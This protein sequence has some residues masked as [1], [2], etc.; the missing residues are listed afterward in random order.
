MS[1]LP[2]LHLRHARDIRM[3]WALNRTGAVAATLVGQ[4]IRRNSRGGVIFFSVRD[5]SGVIQCKADRSRFVPE[6]WEST[7]KAI[8]KGDR[9]SIEGTVETY[10]Y[11]GSSQPI[12]EIL[13]AER[14]LPADGP[15][16]D[17]PSG[18]FST[19]ASG[20]FLA[21]LKRALADALGARG[22]EELEPRYIS[23]SLPPT[24]LE[25]L[26]VVFPGYGSPAYLLVSPIPGLRAARL[27]TGAQKLFAVGRSFS[28]TVRDGYTSAESIVIGLIVIDDGADHLVDLCIELVSGCFSDYG[29]MATNWG[30]YALIDSW[31]RE[32]LPASF[33]TMPVVTTPTILEHDHPAFALA[34]PRP[35]APAQGPQDPLLVVEGSTRKNEF[36]NTE[37]VATIH[38]ERMARAIRDDITFRA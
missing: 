32:A 12:I 20:F 33:G 16:F 31:A 18:D 30:E 15:N 19:V 21:R 5:P 24:K 22:F 29:T 10:T 4:V 27:L 3:F 6:K 9:I 28:Q 23:N 36:G 11:R 7:I 38:V 34:W 25:P 8:R 35:P 13:S 17:S 14:N 37:G 26:Q 1:Q 2:E